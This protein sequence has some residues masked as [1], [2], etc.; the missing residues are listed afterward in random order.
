MKKN[1]DYQQRITL[2][3][4]VHFGRPCVANTRV[5]VEDVL[6]LIQ[7]GISFK[8][9]I[10]KYYPDLRIEDIKACA[11]YATQLVKNEEVHI[12]VG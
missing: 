11:W 1:K 4:Q 6:E 7:E 9:I 3:P 5:P 2:D 10:D 12:G 8:E